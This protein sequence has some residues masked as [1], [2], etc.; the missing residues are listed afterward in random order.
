MYHFP[1][2]CYSVREV[3]YSAIIEVAERGLVHTG[4]REVLLVGG[5]AASK[6]L[7]RKFEAMV[8]ERNVKLY[9]VPPKYAVDNGVM[10]AWTGLLAFKS[11]VQVRPDEAFIKQRWRIDRVDI[12][13]IK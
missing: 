1:D 12:P 3:V 4:K 9:V 10:I 7:R 5:V 13:W 6:Y 11:G 2:I 8:K